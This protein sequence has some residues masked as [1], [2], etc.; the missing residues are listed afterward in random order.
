VKS[1]VLIPFLIVALF[2]SACNSGTPPPKIGTLAPDFTVQDQDRKV[3]LSA[4]RGNIVVLNF[5]ASWCGPCIAETPSLVAM[6]HLLR[7]KGVVVLAVS[8]DDDDSAYHRFIKDQ[9]MDML[10]VRDAAKKSNE[11]YGTFKFPETYIIDRSG[12]VRRKIIGET[13]WTE[14]EMM[15][16]LTKL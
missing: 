1:I 13:N 16:Y 3:T 4:L 12:I 14:Q 2:L 9:G 15:E 11:L 10:T 5:W 7:D 6:H 8:I